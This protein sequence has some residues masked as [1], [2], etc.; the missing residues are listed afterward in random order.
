MDFEQLAAAFDAQVTWAD[1]GK[2]RAPLGFEIRRATDIRVVPELVDGACVA[3]LFEV[4]VGGALPRMTLRREG[5]LDRVGK[6]LGVNRE[7]QLADAEFDAHIYVESEAPEATIHRT[8]ASP[9]A[10]RVVL[11]LLRG[12]CDE[13]TFAGDRVSARISAEALVDP[14]A[15]A[16]RAYVDAIAGL[17]DV[18]AAPAGLPSAAEVTRQR[19]VGHILAMAAA[20]LVLAVAA[21][22]VRPPPTL[23]WG[24]VWAALGLGL[25]LWLGCCVA[26]AR[27]LRGGSDSLR[28]LLISAGFFLTVAPFAGMRAAL[29]VNAALDD[30]PAVARAATLV[31]VG[32]GGVVVT[33]V[34]DPASRVSVPRD[35]VAVSTPLAAGHVEVLARPGAL[36]WAWVDRVVAD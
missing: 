15:P 3:A 24:P 35:R 30:G 7:V 20:W 4:V 25:G 9:A 19:S 26:L 6:A 23:A 18:V 5:A 27:A 21:I 13:L 14:R 2:G 11:A 10:R 8:L 16:V 31:E 1:G 33:L 28:W 34:D 17:R 12:P 22:F 29:A 32:D 36:G